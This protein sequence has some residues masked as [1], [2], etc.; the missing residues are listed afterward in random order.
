ML[1]KTMKTLFKISKM[2]GP[3]LLSICFS[4][5]G[6]ALSVSSFRH[7]RNYSVWYILNQLYGRTNKETNQIANQSDAG[8]VFQKGSI[9]HLFGQLGEFISEETFSDMFDE[10]VSEDRK[11]KSKEMKKHKAKDILR[12]FVE[13]TVRPEAVV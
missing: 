2:T 10:K 7:I 13:Q 9:D 12:L 1:L 11:K 6:F 8:L 4:E 5:I 3:F